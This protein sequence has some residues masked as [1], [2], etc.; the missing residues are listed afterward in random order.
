MVVVAIKIDFEIITWVILYLTKPFFA[1][2]NVLKSS[3]QGVAIGQNANQCGTLVNKK[4]GVSDAITWNLT[5]VPVRCLFSYDIVV[6]LFEKECLTTSVVGGSTKEDGPKW[7]WTIRLHG[8][9]PKQSHCRHLLS[10]TLGIVQVS[11]VNGVPTSRYRQQLASMQ[12][13]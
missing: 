3:Q 9:G 2:A 6:T 1:T 8:F 7:M 13:W 4:P 10:R 5:A 11:N 12:T